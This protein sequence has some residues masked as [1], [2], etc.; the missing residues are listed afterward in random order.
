MTIVV[1]AFFRAWTQTIRRSADLYLVQRCAFGQ[2]KRSDLFYICQQEQ[3]APF[4]AG[5]A[6]V[7]LVHLYQMAR[8]SFGGHSQTIGKELA[9]L[10]GS[11][12]FLMSYQYS[13]G[14]I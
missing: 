8:E 2:I 11:I 13:R 7:C 6:K 9:Q 3:Q 14:G 5:Q 12:P 10:H 1:A 4:F